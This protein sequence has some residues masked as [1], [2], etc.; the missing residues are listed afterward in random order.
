M[1]PDA[2]SPLPDRESKRL[3]ARAARVADQARRT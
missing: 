2:V 3:L 1:A